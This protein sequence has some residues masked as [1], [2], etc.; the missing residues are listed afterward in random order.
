MT[1]K[2]IL[3][4]D[5]QL[6]GTLAIVRS[7][8]K[9]N[10]NVTAVSEE[11][12]AI[13]FYSKYCNKK[14]ISSNPRTNAVEYIKEIQD[15]IKKNDFECIIPFHTY[16]AYL[17]SKYRDFFSDYTIVPPPDFNIFKNAFDKKRLLTTAIKNG[18][19]CPKTYF[20]DDL[21]ELTTS[22]D[23]Y[24]I[25]IKPSKRHG[26]RIEICNTE[27][28]FKEKYAKM[29]NEYGPCIVQEYIPNGGEFGV[30]TLFDFNSNP[31]ALTVQKRVR[32]IN[33]YGG[34]STQR[35]SI[36]DENLVYIAFRLLKAINWSGVA[37]V[38][39]RIDSRDGIPKLMEVNPRFW[40]SLQLS[41]LT[42][43]DFPYLLYQLI[44]QDTPPPKLDFKENVECRWLAG[45]ITGFFRCQNK[46]DF[47]KS[48]FKPNFNFDVISVKDPIPGFASIFSPLRNSCDEEPRVDDPLKLGN[49]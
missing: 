26:I 40:G 5:T 3:V 29:S 12:N 16:T 35:K 49:Q 11:N 19:A 21:D 33:P 8:G 14:F 28:E 6:K 34:V 24:P 48:F 32:S 4:T 1:T 36:K 44:V 13:C 17:F 47:I 43:V 22:I 9:K 30:Y 31:I 15:L 41:I 38:E 18:I 27:S 23:D 37:M 25:V 7:L 39:F 10:M 20:S 42:G 2:N 46:L 45:E